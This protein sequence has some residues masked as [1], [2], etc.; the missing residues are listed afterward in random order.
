LVLKTKLNPNG[1]IIR[2][3]ARLVAKGFLLQKGI[4]Y[5][6]TFSPVARYDTKKLF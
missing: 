4:N 6:E 2:Y 1:E 3:K 5:E